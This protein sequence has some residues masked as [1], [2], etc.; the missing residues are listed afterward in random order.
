MCAGAV[1]RVSTRTP[2]LHVA[3]EDLLSAGTAY[4]V[5]DGGRGI[6]DHGEKNGV[7]P[8]DLVVDAEEASASHIWPHSPPLLKLNSSM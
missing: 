4:F 3:T 1:A 7:N 6:G 5:H 8:S 2:L